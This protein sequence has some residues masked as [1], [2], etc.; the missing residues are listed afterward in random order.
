[1]QPSHLPVA[2]TVAAALSAAGIGGT[3]TW[4]R[5][6]VQRKQ[7]RSE[8]HELRERLL[9]KDA[10]PEAQPQAQPFRYERGE[11]R[12]IDLGRAN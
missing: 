1:M 2:L 10:L 12:V 3:A 9:A 8:L 6:A 5:K 7:E 4:A 11:H